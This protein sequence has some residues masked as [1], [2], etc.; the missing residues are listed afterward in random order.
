[1]APE[2]EARVAETAAHDVGAELH[3]T[4]TERET[5]TVPGAC[6]LAWDVTYEKRRSGWTW[7]ERT[8][9]VVDVDDYDAARSELQRRSIGVGALTHKRGE[10]A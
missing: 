5:E 6:T 2:T 1:M 10:V 9:A 7:T 3:S 8:L 4:R